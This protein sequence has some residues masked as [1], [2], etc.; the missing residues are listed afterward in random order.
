MHRIQTVKLLSTVVLTAGLVAAGYEMRSAGLSFWGL[1]QYLIAGLTIV[2]GGT[3]AALLANGLLS[4]QAVRRLIMGQ[5]HVE[6]Y[7]YLSTTRQSD[8]PLNPDGI[9]FIK[10]DP[11]SGETQVVTTRLDASGAEYSTASEI[12]HVRALGNEIKYLNYFRLTYPGPDSPFGLS[13]GKFISSDDTSSCPN[14]LETQINLTGEGTVRRQVADRIDADRVRHLK[15]RYGKKW[16]TSALSKG[17]QY[18][19]DGDVA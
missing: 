12:A 11:T 9:L 4:I 14:K 19:F 13:S 8:S 17:K 5:S 2:L 18:V 16:M 15:R 3:L 10:H 1:P 6:G 7:W